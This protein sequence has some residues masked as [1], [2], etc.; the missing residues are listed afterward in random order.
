M[1]ILQSL[2][3]KSLA[4]LRKLDLSHILGSSE[5]ALRLY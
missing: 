4:T 2:T 1:T 3:G 5:F